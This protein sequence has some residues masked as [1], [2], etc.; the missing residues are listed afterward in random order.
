[1]A[2]DLFDYTEAY[3]RSSDPHTSQEAVDEVRLTDLEA[4]VLGALREI[5]PNGATSHDIADYLSM[6]LVTVSPRLA[7]LLRKKQIER[8]PDPDTGKW[9]TARRPGG[10]AR[11]L[12]WAIV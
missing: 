7:P 5:H 4:K 1:M 12:H 6:D 10:K 3:A 2:G 8:R 11:I 9:K